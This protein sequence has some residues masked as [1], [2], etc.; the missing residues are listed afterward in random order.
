M[1]VALAGG[2]GALARYELAG[3]VQQ[4]ATRPYP[5]GTLAVNVTGSFLLGVS[6]TSMP[7]H[8][9]LNQ[10]VGIGLLGGF[11]TYSTWMV[12]TEGLARDGGWAGILAAVVNLVAMLTGGLVG[13]GLGLWVGDWARAR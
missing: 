2:L 11:T 10:V 12:E 7:E 8:P 9:G 1:W 5:F 4:R 6:V 3:W 13:V